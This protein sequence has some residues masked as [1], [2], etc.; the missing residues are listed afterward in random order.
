[1]SSDAVIEGVAGSLGAVTAL[2]ATYPLLTINT[3][4]SAGKHSQ[5]R[6]S[7]EQLGRET[8]QPL[9]HRIVQARFI[10]RKLGR[11]TLAH[12][13]LQCIHQFWPLH[14]AATLSQSCAWVAKSQLRAAH[15]KMSPMDIMRDAM[16]WRAILRPL[17]L[18]SLNHEGHE[19]PTHQPSVMHLVQLTRR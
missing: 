12:L 18:C 10:M 3:Q 16:C 6:D 13:S 17:S 8:E 2:V 11:A 15:A 9:L 14:T 5:D 4:Q 19:R 1:M 7:K